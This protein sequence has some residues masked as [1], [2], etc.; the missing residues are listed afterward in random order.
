MLDL[1]FGIFGIDGLPNGWEAMEA[2]DFWR[3]LGQW[4]LEVIGAMDTWNEVMDTRR[5]PSRREIIK[6]INYFPPA[7]SAGGKSLRSEGAPAP[8]ETPPP[9]HRPIGR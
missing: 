1:E 6:I 8:P 9:L 2:I 4:T 7:S 3:R 5:P